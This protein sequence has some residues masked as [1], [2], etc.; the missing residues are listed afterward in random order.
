MAQGSLDGRAALITGAADGVG[1]GMA[2]RFAQ[3]G[4]K[5]I[6]A[7]FNEE[8]GRETTEQLRQLGGTAEFVR[9]DVSQRDQ[10]I[11]AVEATVE[12]FGAIDVLVNNAYR[13]R[14]LHRIEDKT[15]DIFEDA[16]RVCLYAAKWSMEAAMPH[17][18][19]R[20]WGR[21]INICSL[22]GVNAHMGSAEYNAGKEAL[23]SYTRSAAREWARHGICANI[24]CPAAK[25]AAFRTFEKLQPEVAAASSGANP[26][27]RMGDPA[28]DIGGVAL[29]LASE[30]ARYLTGNTLFVDGGAHI[31]GVAWAPDLDN[32]PTFA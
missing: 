20:H 11:G 29:F 16:M 13:G 22:N 14:G 19:A 21:I 6:V 12:K 2:I 17:M 31:N 5:V 23:R 10:V 26:M 25:S 27:G 9:C 15:D 18:R 8:K 32:L 7:D 4:G 3:A 28:D 24:I 1:Q 30:D